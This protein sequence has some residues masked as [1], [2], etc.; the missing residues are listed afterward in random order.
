MGRDEGVTTMVEAKTEAQGATWG[1]E[2][3]TVDAKWLAWVQETAVSSFDAYNAA[4]AER[5]AL[6]A[7][8]AELEAAMPKPRVRRARVKRVA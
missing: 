4:C 1:G 2:A 8:V 7:R 6:R 3:I 5:D